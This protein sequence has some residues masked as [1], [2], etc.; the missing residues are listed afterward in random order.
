MATV[1]FATMEALLGAISVA[2]SVSLSSY[3]LHPGRLLRALEEAGDRGA[4]VRVRLEAHPLGERG[5]LEQRN[6][7]LAAELRRHHV[8]VESTEQ[9][10]HIKA[11]VVDRWAFLDDRNWPDRDE[12]NLLVVD[13]APQD[14]AVTRLAIDGRVAS[15]E[16]LWTR[17]LD[18]L[19]GEAA[20]LH[21]AGHRAVE[22]ETE[23]V[24]PGAVARELEAHARAGDEVR[25]LVCADEAREPRE[26][27]LLRELAAAG[28]AVRTVPYGEK[29]AV[30][31]ARG[32]V[33]SANAGTYPSD[34]ID[35]G[36]RVSDRSLVAA[37]RER[38]AR[39][40]S[41]SEPLSRGEA[42][43]SRSEH[44]EE[45]ACVGVGPRD[46]LV[47]RG[48]EESRELGCR[49]GD[50]GRLVAL[51]AMRNRCEI[52]T[53]GLQ[54][55][56]RE[57]HGSD[58][59]SKRLR[60]LER[61]DPADPQAQAELARQPL[62]LLGSTGEAMDDA[63]DLACP[64]APQRRDEIVERFPLMIDDRKSQG[65]GVGELL[66]EHSQLIRGRAIHV[67]VV[68]PGLADRDR[69]LTLL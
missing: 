10:S 69:S 64:A 24:G 13:G 7:A 16:H 55:D 66:V 3:I 54:D 6:R 58:G 61:E 35:W 36:M 25:L 65:T 68:E 8:T 27:A 60:R 28:V 44:R 40:W 30:A 9:P 48:F 43:R 41:E 62:R 63:R 17:K 39:N 22:V 38:F 18:A 15:D 14:V 29:L 67:M 57:S 42:A 32:W 1:S 46:D 26:A 51:P 31:G 49:C 45:R 52:R 50:V 4:S 37:L 33:G 2:H 12:H 59:I 19:N 21:E 11:A 34:L 53:I 20:L 23:S 47:E 56:M 5:G